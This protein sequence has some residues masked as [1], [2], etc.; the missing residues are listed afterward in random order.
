MKFYY[1]NPK[2][3]YSKMISIDQQKRIDKI[4]QDPLYLINLDESNGLSMNLSGSKGDI[5]V[6]NVNDGQLSCNCPDYTIT[7]KR[8]GLLCKH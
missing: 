5:Y 2:V 8:K 3:S 1:M 6:I 4:Y 7:C